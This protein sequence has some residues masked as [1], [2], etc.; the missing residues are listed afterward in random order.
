M[1]RST[2]HR[3]KTRTVNLQNNIWENTVQAALGVLAH[4]DGRTALEL[5]LRH[6]KQGTC[7]C[8]Y[9]FTRTTAPR[10]GPSFPDGGP[11]KGLVQASA[12]SGRVPCSPRCH[13]LLLLWI[14]NLNSIQSPLTA[15]G[16]HLRGQGRSRARRSRRSGTK[17][18]LR[19]AVRALPWLAL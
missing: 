9:S 19:G 8:S 13:R 15:G 4:V 2:R 14:L 3:G 10:N 18:R 1:K 16:V 5:A 6:P 17:S 12:S 7:S 11:M